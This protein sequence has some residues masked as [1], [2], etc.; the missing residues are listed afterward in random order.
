VFGKSISV[1]YLRSIY[2][3]HIYKDVPKLEH[4]ENIAT[5][6][7]HSISTAMTDYVKKD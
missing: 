7:G 4:L 1:D 5:Q 3:S 2:L 6:M